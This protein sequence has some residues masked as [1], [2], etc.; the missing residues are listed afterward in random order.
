MELDVLAHGE[1]RDA[2]RVALGEIGDGPELGGDQEPVRDPDADHE[3]GCSAALTPLA[4]GHPCAVALRVDPPPAE[5]RLPLG[6]HG[7]EPFAGES[8]NL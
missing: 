1:V 5:V 2:P 3:I 6:R 4:A 8:A 7:A